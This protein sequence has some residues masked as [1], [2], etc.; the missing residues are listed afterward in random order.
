MFHPSDSGKNT[1]VGFGSGLRHVQVG[2][3]MCSGRVRVRYGLGSDRVQVFLSTNFW[4]WW[5]DNDVKSFLNVPPIRL[6]WDFRMSDF[7]SGSNWVRVGFGSDSGK[8][9]FSGQVWWPKM[10]GLP[11]VFE[12]TFEFDGETMTWSHSHSGKNFHQRGALGSRGLSLC[13]ETTNSS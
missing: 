3:G 9:C 7:W 10:S 5:R 11:S 2:F 6:K 1:K 12:S 4:I 13:G 8:V